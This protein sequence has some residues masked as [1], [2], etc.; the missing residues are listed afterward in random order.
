MSAVGSLNTSIELN[1][2]DGKSARLIVRPKPAVKVSRPFTW[3]WI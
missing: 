1:S 3:V 2:S